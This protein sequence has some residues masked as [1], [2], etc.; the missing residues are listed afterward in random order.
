MATMIENGLLLNCTGADVD[1]AVQRF[2]DGWIEK[3][4]ISFFATGIV[5]NVTSGSQM[6]VSGIKDEVTGEA[7]T[8]KGIIAF[9]NPT[10]TTTYQTSGSKPAVVTFYKNSND[11]VGALIA[12]FSSIYSVRINTSTSYP[13]I[14]GNGFTYRADTASMYGLMAAP[15]WRWVAWG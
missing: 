2:K 15:R 4:K 1:E 3:T 9:I 6:S 12:A 13:S 8:P 14:S 10:S 7:F 11:S 5:T